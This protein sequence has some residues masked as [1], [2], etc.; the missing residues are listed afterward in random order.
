MLS[1]APT[2]G[3]YTVWAIRA[4]KKE[5]SQTCNT[6]EEAQKLKAEW[7]ALGYVAEVVERRR[8]QG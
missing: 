7:E 5:A 3:R 4:G 6:M 1:H 8:P 2:I